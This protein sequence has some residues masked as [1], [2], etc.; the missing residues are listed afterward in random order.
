MTE[1]PPRVKLIRKLVETGHSILYLVGHPDYERPLLLKQLHPDLAYDPIENDYLYRE[2]KIGKMLDLAN[3]PKV[4][5]Y[6]EEGGLPYILMEYVD[7][8]DL[9]TRWHL[10]SPKTE[11]LLRTVCRVAEILDE[12]HRHGIVHRDVKPENIIIDPQGE[13]WLVDFGLAL[14]RDLTPPSHE[15]GHF[16]GTLPYAAPERLKE[17]TP[18][19][20]PRADVYSIGVLLH[21]ALTGKVPFGDLETED[22]FLG[23]TSISAPPIEPLRR[24]LPGEIAGNQAIRAVHDRALDPD[25]RKRFPHALAVAWALE[26]ALRSAEAPPERGSATQDKE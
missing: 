22:F 8:E 23:K 13:P 6:G 21:L 5:A 9:F 7:G 25:P 26:L 19:P 3:V 15:K 2:F 24:D 12:V 11:E 16:V 17:F 18:D 14:R 20:D 1:L 4:Y 10:R